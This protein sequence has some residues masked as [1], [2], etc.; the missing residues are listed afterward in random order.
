[1][2]EIQENKYKE[3]GRYIDGYSMIRLIKEVKMDFDFLSSVN[4][5]SI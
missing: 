4:N 1:M 3:D 2:V 5:S